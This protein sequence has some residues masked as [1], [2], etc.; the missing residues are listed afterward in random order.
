MGRPVTNY[1]PS[2][3]IDHLHESAT[4]AASRAD[5]ALRAEGD[6]HRPQG[7]EPDFD[8]PVRDR[9]GAS[10]ARRRGHAVHVGRRHRAFARHHA[11]DAARPRPP[12]D[13]SAVVVSAGTK[14]EL[15]N[16][17][18]ALFA[19]GDEVLVPTPGWTSYYEMLTIARATAVAVTGPRE[20]AFKI[21]ARELERARTAKTRGLILNSPSNPTGAVYSRAELEEI[22]A[23]ADESGWWILSDEI[24]RGICY[25]GEATSLLSV[26]PSSGRLVVVDGLAKSMAMP[27]WRIGWS[28]APFALARSMS[29]L[30]SHTRQRDDHPQHAALSAGHERVPIRPRRDDAQ[31]STSRRCAERVSVGFEVLDPKARSTCSCAPV[32]VPD[33]EPGTRAAEHLLDAH[34]VVVAGWRSARRSVRGPDRDVFEVRRSSPRGLILAARRTRAEGGG[35]AGM[36]AGRRSP[37]GERQLRYDRNSLMP[38]RG[39]GLLVAAP[40]QI[41]ARLD[42][43]RGS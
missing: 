28:I 40:M 16:A 6:R 42:W 31:R 12:V 21:S 11:E 2:S 24:Y 32:S 26:A 8:A 13:A 22:V 20:N 37:Y 15:F 29:A 5:Q 34:D 4:I 35:G 25:S 10:S 43:R 1:T 9:R 18:F 27:G 3:N 41:D 36:G 33:P 39:V 19:A 30:Q 14:R 23:F 7:G 38:A 17:C